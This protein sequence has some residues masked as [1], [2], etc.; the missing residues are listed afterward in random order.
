MKEK[1]KDTRYSA[2]ALVHF[3]DNSTDRFFLKDISLG[4]FSVTNIDASINFEMNR[5]YRVTIAPEAEAGVEPFELDI[6]FCWTRALDEAYE[7][8]GL[9]SGYP[10]GK[11][12]QQFANYLAWRALF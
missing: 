4:G 3:T 10:G 2:S 8:G 9:I 5:D 11:R 1:R 6:A 7:A 12:Y